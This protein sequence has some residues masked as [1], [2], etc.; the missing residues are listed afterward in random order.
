MLKI[1]NAVKIFSPGTPNEHKAL[2]SLSLH[3]DRGEFVTI[4]GSNGAGKSTTLNAVAGV[5]PVDSGSIIIDGINVTGLPE[6]KRAKYLG[7]VFQDPMTALNPVKTVGEQ[8]AEVVLLH[9][10]CSKVGNY[11]KRAGT[12]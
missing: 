10:H 4:V 3:L 1:D 8:I 6:H 11:K 9:S 5:W 12:V 7:R 2:N